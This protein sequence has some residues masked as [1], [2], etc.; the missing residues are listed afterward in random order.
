MPFYPILLHPNTFL[1]S[2]KFSIIRVFVFNVTDKPLRRPVP[3]SEIPSRK[4]LER[5]TRFLIHRRDVLLCH[6]SG[7]FLIN[8][9]GWLARVQQ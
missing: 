7:A 6:I 1:L 8:P 9:A 3:S 2:W 5:L 4:L